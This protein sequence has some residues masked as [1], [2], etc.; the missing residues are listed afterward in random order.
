VAGVRNK[1]L[2]MNLS[3]RHFLNLSASAAALPVVSR[4]AW[5]QAFPAR[6]VRMIVGFAAGGPT[7]IVA[8]LMGQRLS[9]RLGQPF[10][11]ENRPGAAGNIAT[12]AALKAAPDGYTLLFVSASNAVNVTL[13]DKVDFSFIR[14]I[15]PVAGIIRAPFVM[16]V[17]PT[18]PA[19][20]VPE[21]IA[22]AKSNP[23]K[24][25]FASGGNGSSQHLSGELFKMMTGVEMVH[26]P[27]RG[28]AP[29]VTDLI[30]G[31]VQVMFDNVV[32]S[33]GHIRAGTL[34][35]LAVTDAA[36][37]EIL[38]DVPTTGEFL[39]GY[40]ATAWAGLVAPKNTPV[41]IVSVLN[42]EINTALDDPK[43]KVRL[44]DLGG[45]ALAGSPADFG[46]FL[47]AETDKW[48]KVVRFANLKAD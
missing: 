9:E 48:G 3:R 46:K 7:D 24:L 17:N 26:V 36:R 21:L 27:Y 42:Q 31:Q 40:E 10:I 35:A 4:T 16:E 13:Y 28:S 1:G 15:A 19:K 14:D 29:A 12:E 43:M 34:R 25:N 11:I 38:P 47:A 37:S 8:R 23:G 30:G 39:P 33:I 44:A 6:P 18:V 20:T 41:E 5:A 2:V 32:S 22:Y 45:T